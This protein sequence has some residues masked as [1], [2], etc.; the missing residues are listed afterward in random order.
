MFLSN[1]NNKQKDLF[2]K[3]AIKAAEANGIVSIEEKNMLKC[4]SIEMDIEP[5][6][7]TDESTDEI[8]DELANASNEQD[9][10]VITFEILA[11]MISDSE[12]DD[13]EK[14]FVNSMI[15][16]FCISKEKSREMQIVLKDYLDVC[17]RI[18]KIVI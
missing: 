5:F 12:F 1:L 7:S 4:F 16:K 11:I 15:D 9:L 14:A 6:Y 8:L 3:L 17:N 18:N 13:D 10:R 2:Q